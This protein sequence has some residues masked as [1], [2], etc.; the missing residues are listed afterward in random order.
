MPMARQPTGLTAT[1]NAAIRSIYFDHCLVPVSHFPLL[2]TK[3]DF[4]V[5]QQSSKRRR[6]NSLER[7]RDGGSE[8]HRGVGDPV[9]GEV[10]IALGL[11]GVESELLQ[12]ELGKKSELLLRSNP[13]SKK[14]PVLLHRGRPACESMVIVQYI[15]AVWAASGPAILPAD[16]YELVLHRFW[17]VYIDDSVSSILWWPS[18]TIIGKAQTEEAKAEAIEQALTGLTLFGGGLRESEQRKRFLSEGTTSLSA[19]SKRSRS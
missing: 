2:N 10:G 5:S 16:H 9:R 17:V 19:G 11:K 12:D 18:V 1:I 7:R 13:V 14:I 6:G 15:D 3:S 8:A 4:A